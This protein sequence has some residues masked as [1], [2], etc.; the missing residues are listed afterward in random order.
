VKAVYPTLTLSGLK[1]TSPTA[2][3]ESPSSPKEHFSTLKEF[4]NI[5]GSKTLQK[6]LLP[7]VVSQP[8][9]SSSSTASSEIWPLVKNVRIWYGAEVLKTGAVLVDLPG[10]ADSNVACA[11]VAK[12][13]VKRCDSIWIVDLILEGY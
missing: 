2:L 7:F 10:L 6:R 9:E 3:L 11:N 4:S 13:Y 1:D 5:R 8:S 12:G